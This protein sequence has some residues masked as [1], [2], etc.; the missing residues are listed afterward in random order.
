MKT[1]LSKKIQDLLNKLSRKQWVLLGICLLIL[2]FNAVAIAKELPLVP[3]L[4]AGVILA[5]FL[6]FRVDLA[7]YLMALSTPFS[8]ILT[9]KNVNLGLSLP[10]EVIMISLT[11]LFL[12]RIIYDLRVE[13]KLVKHPISIAI[14]STFF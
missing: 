14:L 9:V 10:S 12:A 7:M 5:Y 11:L 13:P 2:L 6:I 4:T 3:L 1:D 8:V